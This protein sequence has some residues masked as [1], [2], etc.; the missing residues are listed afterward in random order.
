MQGISTL[1]KEEISQKVEEMEE[2]HSEMDK[3][4]YNSLMITQL[5]LNNGAFLMI[6]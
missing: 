2:T 6:V 4:T 3:G 5:W 1:L